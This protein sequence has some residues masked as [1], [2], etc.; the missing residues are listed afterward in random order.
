MNDSLGFLSEHLGNKLDL[1][2]YGLERHCSQIE[3]K[4]MW[5]SMI[6]APQQL[7]HHDLYRTGTKLPVAI[8][9]HDLTDPLNVGSL[10]RLADALGVEKLYLSGST[11]TPP[12]PKIR[13][14]AR[15]T[16]HA[17]AFEYMHDP[18]RILDVLRQQ[19]Y[20]SVSL[21]LTRASI[22]I[23]SIGEH[24][25]DRVCLI[26]GSENDGVNEALLAASDLHVH[27]P[28]QGQNSSM[29]VIT[30]AAIAIYAI[31]RRFA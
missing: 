15:S 10:F 21:E 18:L 22:D 25:F 23:A 11:P 20:L 31:S 30:A 2:Q 4:G 13:K 8:I 6:R 24:K 19:G 9:A 3:F 26:L 14:T 7:E 1:I 17:V 12:H 5:Q 28:M 29:N 27:I 16:E